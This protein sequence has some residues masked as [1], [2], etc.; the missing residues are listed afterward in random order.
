MT[1]PTDPRASRIT[2]TTVKKLSNIM[3]RYNFMLFVGPDGANGFNFQRF[4]EK[5]KEEI[6]KGIEDA[7]KQTKN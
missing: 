1:K 6:R 5:M 7:K 4:R 2:R 3:I